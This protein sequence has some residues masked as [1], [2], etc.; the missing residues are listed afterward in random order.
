M[1]HVGNTVRV[2][3]EKSGHMVE[4]TRGTVERLGDGFVKVSNKHGSEMHRLAHVTLEKFS[5]M[6]NDLRPAT[7]PS[8]PVR[9]KC[10][11]PKNKAHF[12]KRSMWQSSREYW[13]SRVIS[14]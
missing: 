10:P 4:L 9:V 8:F 11:R 12:A 5:E 3:A 14:N 1:V 6:A 13:G 2:W 7:M